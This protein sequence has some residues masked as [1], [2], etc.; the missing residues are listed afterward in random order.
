MDRQSLTLRVASAVLLVVGAIGILSLP[1]GVVRLLEHQA[2]GRMMSVN[3]DQE[4]M[5]QGKSEELRKI[6]DWYDASTSRIIIAGVAFL[7]ISFFVLIMIGVIL[8]RRTSPS[9]SGE[10]RKWSSLE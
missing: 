2:Q 10:L 8:W 1:F 3:L 7:A 5:A 6:N 4:M 9:R